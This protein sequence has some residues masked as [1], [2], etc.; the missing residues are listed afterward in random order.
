MYIC[1]FKT[2]KLIYICFSIWYISKGT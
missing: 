1:T 2:D